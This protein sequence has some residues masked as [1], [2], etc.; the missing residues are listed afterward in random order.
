MKRRK[1]NKKRNRIMY[2][3]LL[4]TMIL[5]LLFIV[6]LIVCLVTFTRR[7]NRVI[8]TGV[9]EVENNTITESTVEITEDIALKEKLEKDAKFDAINVK[10][11]TVPIP[12]GITEDEIE[13]VDDYMNN[14]FKILL[15]NGNSLFYNSNIVDTSNLNKVKDIIYEETDTNTVVNIVLNRIYAFWTKIDENNIYIKVVEVRDKYDKV[16][17]LDAG[18]GGGDPGTS[19]GDILEKDINLS[20]LLKT[21]A[22]LDEQEE[23]KVYYTRTIDIK[24]SWDARVNLANELKADMF[25]SIHSN[26]L[27]PEKGTAT[28]IEVM[29]DQACELEGFTSKDLA[30]ICVTELTNTIPLRNRGVI[31]GD[32]IYIIRNSEVPVALIELGFLSNEEDLYYLTTDSEQDKMAQSITRIIKKA[33]KE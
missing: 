11:I 32:S 20:V 13:F 3:K 1:R 24:P 10:V 19:K 5:V 16:V 30:E 22:I 21:K 27:E 7:N 14:T 4:I 28:G 9:T 31:E 33:Y 6:A 8:N 29:Y 23:I 18:H 17:V 2:N 25:I 26:Y 12:A 15:P